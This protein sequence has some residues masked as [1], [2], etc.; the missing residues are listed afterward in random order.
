MKFVERSRAIR[1]NSTQD[2]IREAGDAMAKNILSQMQGGQTSPFKVET[3]N[4]TKHLSDE[5]F[6]L[7]STT[8]AVQYLGSQRETE[9]LELPLYAEELTLKANHGN[10]EKNLQVFFARPSELSLVDPSVLV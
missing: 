5:M 3:M 2:K 1:R 9:G 6:L 8:R 4:P 10:S 7:R